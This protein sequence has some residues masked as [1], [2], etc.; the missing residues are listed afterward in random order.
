MDA[1]EAGRRHEQT[2]Q[3]A[4]GSQSEERY[5]PHSERHKIPQPQLVCDLPARWNRAFSR[6]A[7]LVWRR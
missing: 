3:T 7:D 2:Q 6:P 5:P 1:N 4:K